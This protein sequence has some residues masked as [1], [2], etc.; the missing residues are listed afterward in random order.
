MSRRL[1]KLSPVVPLCFLA[2]CAINRDADP[3]TGYHPSVAE[4]ARKILHNGSRTVIITL[5]EQGAF[6][7][8]PETLRL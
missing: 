2:G 1:Y 4:A 6:L 7:A 5:A 8:S 3:Q